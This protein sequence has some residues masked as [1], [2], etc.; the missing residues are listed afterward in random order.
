MKPN[1]YPDAYAKLEVWAR[2]RWPSAGEAL[3]KWTGQASKKSLSPS[4]IS[5]IVKRNFICN[6]TSNNK[7]IM[8]TKFACG[9]LKT[10]VNHRGRCNESHIH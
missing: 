7:C 10:G 3:Y 2:A 9:Y 5:T 4:M 8:I 6:L 1:E